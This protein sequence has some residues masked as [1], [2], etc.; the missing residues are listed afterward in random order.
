[1]RRFPSTSCAPRCRA[2]TRELACPSTSYRVWRP[3]TARTTKWRGCARPCIGRGPSG[4]RASPTPFFY[5]AHD[6]YLPTP[7]GEPLFP[8]DITV[9]A[10]YLVRN[11]L[12]V[13]VSWTFFAGYDGFSEGVDFVCNARARLRGPD[14][15]RLGQRLLDWSGHVRNWRAAAALQGVVAAEPE[16]AAALLRLGDVYRGTGKLREALECYR[17]VAALRPGD[18][19]A[20]WLVA[21]LSGKALPDS[22]RT[23]PPGFRTNALR[24]RDGLSCAAA[25]P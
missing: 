25:L 12:D 11:P 16:N 22:P 9:A 19:T 4:T 13:A 20:S 24:A 6:A 21:I 14:W 18:S 1:M 3:R 2:A 8:D 5:V 15:T 23:P 7:G 17:R 10:V